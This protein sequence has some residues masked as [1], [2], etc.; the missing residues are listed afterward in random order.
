MTLFRLGSRGSPL[1]LAQAHMTRAAL[2]TAHGWAEDD[3]AIV[4][5]K[6]TGDQVQDRAL[7]E[8]GGKALW[9][10]ELDRALLAGEIDAAVHSMKD[11]ETERPE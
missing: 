5:I 9:T 10:K 2:C 6:T 4:I 11:V 8:I 7:A 1:A 3:V